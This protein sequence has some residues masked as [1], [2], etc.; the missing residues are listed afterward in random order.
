MCVCVCVL[1]LLFV[2]LFVWLCLFKVA[3]PHGYILRG[4]IGHSV[5]V[6]LPN[7]KLMA[8]L[9]CGSELTLSSKQLIQS[10][11]GG[12]HQIIYIT[13]SELFYHKQILN[14]HF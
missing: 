10:Y 12:F 7:V 14:V 6:S 3:M 8:Q 2:C 1:L 9:V 5:D 13:T 11:L 4:Q